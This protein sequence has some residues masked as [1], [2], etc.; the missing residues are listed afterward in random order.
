MDRSDGRRLLTNCAGCQLRDTIV[1]QTTSRRREGEHHVFRSHAR[2][3]CTASSARAMNFFIPDNKAAHRPRRGHQPRHLARPSRAVSTIDDVL[4]LSV[5]RAE[6]GAP[7]FYDPQLRP[8]RIVFAETNAPQKES[9]RA[10]RAFKLI[11]ILSALTSYDL[12][13][14]AADPWEHTNL[15]RRPR[16]RSPP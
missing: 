9:R 10:L 15:R 13:D 11:Y 6:P 8:G 14:L 16:R 3:R 2:T 5:S 7:L 12:Y 1:I 4:D